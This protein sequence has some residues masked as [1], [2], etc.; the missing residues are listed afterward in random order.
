[1]ATYASKVKDHA[2][3]P[4]GPHKGAFYWMNR[5][6]VFKDAERHCGRN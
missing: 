1:M 2:L 3:S 5:A 4:V 6:S